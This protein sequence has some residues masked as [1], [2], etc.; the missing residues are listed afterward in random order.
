MFCADCT[1][2]HA[3][4]TAQNVVTSVSVNNGVF[5]CEVCA[6]AHVC[7]NKPEISLVKQLNVYSWTEADVKMIKAAGNQR[8]SNFISAYEFP[9]YIDSFNLKKHD[10]HRVVYGSKA[11][12]FWR[13][14]LAAI[15]SGTYFDDFFP[16]SREEG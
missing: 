4:E 16:P 10:I 12:H 7:M 13:Q 15:A 11:C 2:F 8:F 1:N 14:R 5:L 6:V 9:A 3:R